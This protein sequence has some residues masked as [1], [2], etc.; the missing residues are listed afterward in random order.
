MD[1]EERECAP[2]LPADVLAELRSDHR[3]LKAAGM[4]PAALDRH[5]EWEELIFARYVPDSIRAQIELDHGAAA[6]GE[7][8]S[9]KAGG[10]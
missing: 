8:L 5:S 9:K 4:H 2:Y 1:F 6:R 3:R 10:T 7:L